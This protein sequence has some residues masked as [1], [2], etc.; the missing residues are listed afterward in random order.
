[1]AGLSSLLATSCAA[2]AASLAG[3]AVV[4]LR[5]RWTRVSA[6]PLAAFAGGAILGAAFL[7]L[8]PEAIERS[9][10]SAC[11]WALAAFFAIYVLEVHVIPHQHHHAH[12][13]PH[14]HEEARAEAAAHAAIPGEA[15]A[16]HVHERDLAEALSRARS[17][18]AP[19]AVIA[20]IAF[21]LHS[22]FDGFALGVG[23]SPEVHM[24][25]A[26]TL[27][28]LAHKVPEGIALAA[29]LL[30]R[31][32]PGRALLLALVIVLLTPIAALVS[33]TW[34][35]GA[36]APETFGHLLGLVAGAF[37][38]VA[39]ADLLPEVAAHPRLGRTLLLLL[40]VGLAIV[41]RAVA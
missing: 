18:A 37:V 1:M 8:L 26:A 25:A 33:W 11:D 20:A 35:A 15:H 19:F 13:G 22:S 5:P 29:L 23:M 17:S 16:A 27:G 4:H 38:Y 3:V 10:A 40:G 32:T 7:D 6:L 39:T 12:E 36:V 28:V 2:A 9:G 41:V 34:L 14:G 21:A 31:L 24:G 30:G